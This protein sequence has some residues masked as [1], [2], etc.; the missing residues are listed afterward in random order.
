MKKHAFSL[1]EAL[2]SF[3]ILAVFLAI[4]VP[5]ITG[6]S[7][8]DGITGYFSN[9]EEVGYPV[10][11]KVDGFEGNI[12]YVKAGA[13]DK[14]PIEVDGVYYKN[15]GYGEPKV[16]K[17]KIFVRVS[18]LPVFKDPT[19]ENKACVAVFDVKDF[20]KIRDNQDGCF[21]LMDDIN[22]AEYRN[23][24]TQK[25]EPWT[26]SPIPSFSGRLYGNGKILYNLPNRLFDELK[27]GALIQ[28]FGIHDSTFIS[29]AL[30]NSVEG[31]AQVEIRNIYLRDVKIKKP[32][33]KAVTGEVAIGGLIDKVGENASVKI[34][35]F[36]NNAEFDIGKDDNTEGHYLGGIIGKTE[37]R[38]LVI[39]RSSNYADMKAIKYTIGGLVGLNQTGKVDIKYSLNEGS[40]NGRNVGGLIASSLG[41]D[42]AIKESYSKCFLTAEGFSGGLVGNID[43]ILTINDSYAVNTFSGGTDVGGMVGKVYDNIKGTYTVTLD[44]TYVVPK[45]EDLTLGGR[46]GLF[47]GSVTNL[48][49]A[50]NN[51]NYYYLGKSSANITP[52]FWGTN[53]D[54]TAT[55]P[56]AT[57]MTT[58]AWKD[59]KKWFA[60]EGEGAKQ[61]DLFTT[62]NDKTWLLEKKFRPI[63]KRTPEA[64]TGQYDDGGNYK[65]LP[66]FLA[67][68]M[69]EEEFIEAAK[70]QYEDET[71]S[72][73]EKVINTF[74]NL[75]Q[76]CES[77]AI[78][79]ERT[80]SKENWSIP[81][82]LTIDTAFYAKC[83]ALKA[84]V[85]DRLASSK[86][87]SNRRLRNYLQHINCVYESPA[88]KDDG[89]PEKCY[90]HSGATA[91]AYTAC[92][93][94]YARWGLTV[95]TNKDGK[96]TYTLKDSYEASRYQPLSALELKESILASMKINAEFPRPVRRMGP[97]EITTKKLNKGY[98]VGLCHPLM[99]VED[100]GKA[101]W[102][103]A[104]YE[105][106]AWVPTSEILTGG[107]KYNPNRNQGQC[108]VVVADFE[109]ANELEYTPL[110]FSYDENARNNIFLGGGH[111]VSGLK[112][113]SKSKTCVSRSGRDSMD[114]NIN[115]YS[116]CRASGLFM[117]FPQPK[118]GDGSINDIAVKNSK[119]EAYSSGTYTGAN[120]KKNYDAF[121]DV[122]AGICPKLARGLVMNTSM[123]NVSLKGYT[124]SSK[125][126]SGNSAAYFVNIYDYD[127]W[128]DDGGKDEDS[129]TDTPM[130]KSLT[131]GR[132][133][134]NGGMQGIDGGNYN[135]DWWPYYQL[136]CWTNPSTKELEC[137]H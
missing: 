118:Y 82:S 43:N 135:R 34:T 96:K 22:F 4:V 15:D 51:R 133:Y 41:E 66:D 105:N 83:D 108:Y 53:S 126:L 81:Q 122:V 7:D 45:F 31:G 117:G 128:V 71:L 3:V 38:R 2:V 63:L 67:N 37:S 125:A 14:D 1:M 121:Y 11:K 84:K 87:K 130:P 107:Y 106:G 69:T 129:T 16:K 112:S 78:D 132:R 6:I 90:W 35:L 136:T 89:T 131:I 54:S 61:A 86:D 26:W 94:G 55:M 23:K 123:E 100:N 40:L 33:S 24:E 92:Y 109:P 93:G 25:T 115:I 12:I 36:Q 30:A 9:Y 50:T 20:N 75:D 59:N 113:I 91:T 10:T 76:L 62:F 127:T 104:K 137:K 13:N 99:L 47:I 72:D 102:H 8:A 80:I 57:A 73:D 56:E 77:G 27:S 97:T 111:F 42:V 88:K 28:D 52:E 68:N 124:H 39:S 60:A 58:V 21:V 95:T 65:A 19:G 98:I 32:D 103:I 18:D 120:E 85:E 64:L 29:G 110:D 116:S 48:D 119:F 49:V 79:C 134:W 114:V 44:N 101:V 74:F 5:M 70:E 46:I 17:R